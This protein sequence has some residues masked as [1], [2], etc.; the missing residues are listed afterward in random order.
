M[1]KGLEGSNGKMGFG[2][3][4]L[5]IWLEFGRCMVRGKVKEIS[6]CYVFGFEFYFKDDGES[7]KGMCYFSF[8]FY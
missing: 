1:I 8:V 5:F 2:Y 4:K 7:L 3:C 6:V